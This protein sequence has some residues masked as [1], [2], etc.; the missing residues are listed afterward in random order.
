MWLDKYEV[1][2]NS[3]PKRLPMKQRV[4]SRYEVVEHTFWADHIKLCTK[5]VYRVI[6]NLEKR[7]EG[8]SINDCY[9]HFL[10][11]FPKA[12]NAI[13]EIFW[14]NFKSHTNV[15]C[16]LQEKL[17]QVYVK[18]YFIHNGIIYKGQYHRG[19]STKCYLNPKEH[20]VYY[21][22]QYTGERVS[23]E[24]YDKLLS[25]EYHYSLFAQHG[26]EEEGKRH[27]N[28]YPYPMWGFY[29][30]KDNS[31]LKDKR[32]EV[33]YSTKKRKF[34]YRLYKG[35][36]IKYD[37]YYSTHDYRLMQIRYPKGIKQVRYDN[38]VLLTPEH[39]EYKTVRDSFRNPFKKR[40]KCKKDFSSFDSVLVY[41]KKLANKKD[42]NRRENKT[43]YNLSLLI[44]RSLI[45]YYSIMDKL[46]Y[47]STIQMYFKQEVPNYKIKTCYFEKNL[48]KKLESQDLD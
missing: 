32:R 7:Y 4:T 27:Y 16:S 13:R 43:L 26:L 45:Q 46:D 12:D 37:P 11:I 18:N 28:G 39:P 15:D 6:K 14:D 40:K 30:G 22:D 47:L 25:M 29:Y 5:Q 23:S 41:T 20:G 1:K 38:R 48:W 44:P 21:I 36:Y 31:I 2:L 8:K 17:A 19:I 24:E 35:E 9:S 3:L 34:Y 33:F 42:R 10:R